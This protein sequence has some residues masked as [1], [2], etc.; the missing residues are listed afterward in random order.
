MTSDITKDDLFRAVLALDV[1]HRGYNSGLELD[2]TAG[3]K[4]GHATVGESSD[5]ESHIGGKLDENIGF[6]ALEYTLNGQP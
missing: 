1:Y 2:D 5:T 4:I 3:T 6:Y